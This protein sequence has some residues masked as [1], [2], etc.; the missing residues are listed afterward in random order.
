M[1]PHALYLEWRTLDQAGASIRAAFLPY[2]EQHLRDGL[3]LAVKVEELQDA[4]TLRQLRFYWGVVLKEISEQAKINDIG[5]TAQ[6]WHLFF[7]RQFLGYQ[8]KKTQLPG[9]KRPSITRTLRSTTGLSVKKMGVY[10]EQ[11]QA[12]AAT[13]FGVSFSA[14]HFEHSPSDLPPQ[15][16][17]P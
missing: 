5:A 3:C 4:R 17:A 9:A 12:S 14:S 16:T 1:N 7:K 6:G 2:V 8:F 11:V 10:L 15:E 13:D